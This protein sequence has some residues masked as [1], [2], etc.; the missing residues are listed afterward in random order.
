MTSLQYPWRYFHNIN[1]LPFRAKHHN[2]TCIKYPEDGICFH[3]L[4]ISVPQYRDSPRFIDYNIGL[5]KTNVLLKQFQKHISAVAAKDPL[6]K[7]CIHSVRIMLCQYIL[8]PCLEDGSFIQICRRDCDAYERQCPKTLQKLIGAAIVTL[9]ISNSNFVHV[10][11]PDCQK[12]QYEDDL[13]KV[14]KKC[15]L[16]GLFSKWG[17][18]QAPTQT[19]KYFKLS[20]SS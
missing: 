19:R 10:S 3:Y 18:N 9:S 8:T 13:A 1:L 16:T 2:G 5:N 14:G 6:S 4:N 20:K 7:S 17:V 15:Y 11:L 12:F